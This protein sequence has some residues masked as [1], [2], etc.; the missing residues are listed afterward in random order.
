MQSMKFLGMIA[1]ASAATSVS[2]VGNK[3][4]VKGDV[5]HT[6][7]THVDASLLGVGYDFTFYAS[8]EGKMSGSN[9]VQ[10]DTYSA[11]ADGKFSTSGQF[12]GLATGTGMIPVMF[13]AN[14]NIDA[15]AN[16]TA[17]A[18]V[19]RKQETALAGLLTADLST[20][21]GAIATTVLDVQEI[22]MNGNTVATWLLAGGLPVV[23]TTWAAGVISSE[24]AS[25]VHS[26]QHTGTMGAK[27]FIITMIA[28]D[29]AGEL[30]SGGLLT[31]SSVELTFDCSGYTL[32]HES[33]HLRLRMG[34]GSAAASVSASA[35]G[36]VNGQIKAGAIKRL[37]AGAAKPK[38]QVWVD[39][40]TTAMSGTK[41]VD[42]KLEVTPFT[43]AQ[44]KADT[45]VNGNVSAD[46]LGAV[47]AAFAGA[48][49]AGGEASA[50]VKLVTIDFP[51]NVSTFFYDP[52]VG[53]GSTVDI[54]WQASSATALS[55]MFSAL[56][57][58]FAAL[59]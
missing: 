46:I 29:Q 17:G 30:S 52:T 39:F 5:R 22:D 23:G 13:L 20:S 18:A 48:A 7:L 54:E 11:G 25:P 50:D 19:R 28:T 12:G 14:Y 42:V 37:V 43:N 59:F 6:S 41:S 15:T 1:A 34:V 27:K 36:N 56:F 33:N 16:A 35:N 31:P 4:G 53:T 51:A 3:H 44:A 21:A 26:V 57:C 9:V 58:A 45:S 40:A 2:F 32:A 49:T 38:S 8:I 24:A 47:K 10:K 55:V